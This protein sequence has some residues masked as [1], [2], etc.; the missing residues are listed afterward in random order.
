VDRTF[1][2][3]PGSG[4]A[5]TEENPTHDRLATPPTTPVTPGSVVGMR[6]T[7]AL[8]AATAVALLAGGWIGYTALPSSAADTGLNRYYQQHL[9]WHGCQQG[10]DDADG[11]ALDQIGA[12]CADV[13]VPLDYAK[14]DGRT[15]TVAISRLA[16]S[17][18]AH[19]IG[20]LVINLGGPGIPVVGRVV[21]AHFAMGATGARFDLIGMDVRFTG[22]S[23]P[24]DCG[25][26]ANWVRSA[27]ASRN[28]FNS[29][30]ALSADLAS[31]CTRSHGDVLPFASS[32]AIVRDLD[33][34]RG[35]LGEPKLSYLGYSYGSYFAALYAQQFP[36]RTDRLV[37]DSAIDP[38]DP[39]THIH[40]DNTAE[41]DQ[42]LRDWAGW[43]AARDSQYHLGTTPDQ[44][45]A[46]VT[47]VYQAS[48]RK[49]LQVGQFTV[50][51]TV[52]PALLLDPLSDDNDANSAELA[53]R[54][55]LMAQ[56]ASGATVEPGPDLAVAL[57]GV[58]TGAQSA[59]HSGQTAIECADEAVPRDPETYWR[60][61]EASRAASPL[62][63][64]L[65]NG[66]SPCAFWSA[67]PQP[68]PLVHNR[69]PALIV[70]ADGDIGAT[71]ELNRAMHRALTGSRLLT[72]QGVRTHGV[73]LFA[74]V[75]CIDDTV[76][77]YLNTGTLPAGD[78]TCT[79]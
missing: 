30:V 34:L 28:S 61:V 76:N 2:A 71:D 79:R 6:R 26:P 72:L 23:T 29:T 66:I 47:S 58:L 5:G 56:A 32:Q 59:I 15:I 4:A 74:G 21:D 55:Q 46:T 52:M 75:A 43:A 48:A 70:H 53:T 14:P 45:V 27:G 7:H 68:Q 41:R 33:L 54:V 22:R 25:W 73:Y 20:P 19:R 67:R 63:G 44:V 18:T 62:F 50:D 38:A 24:L 31:R 51:D 17:D 60:A 8:T 16:A 40:S 42:A 36:S 1:G 49:P 11:A 77:G 12:R 39:G 13:T 3:L 37:L 64:P 57:A 10:P 69:V 35:A 65:E 9:T 78:G